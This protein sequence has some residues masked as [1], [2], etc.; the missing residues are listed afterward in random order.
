MQYQNILQ[1]SVHQVYETSLILL[2]LLVVILKQEIFILPIEY[3]KD[4]HRDR[5]QQWCRY[6]VSEHDPKYRNHGR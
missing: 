5:I 2:G 3:E 4:T 6:R 1:Q